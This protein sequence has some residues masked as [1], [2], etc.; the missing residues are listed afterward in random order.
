MVVEDKINN[1][2]KYFRSFE[3]HWIPA[4][5][6][7]SGRPSEGFLCGIKRMNSA[8]LKV[9]LLRRSELIIVELEVQ[10]VKYIILFRFI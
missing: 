2:D 5:K 4:I 8:K 3:L 6:H 1:Y 9:N 10:S 7:T